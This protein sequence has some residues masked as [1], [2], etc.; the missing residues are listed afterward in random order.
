MTDLYIHNTKIDTLE[1]GTFEGLR[2]LIILE[3]YKCGVNHIKENALKAIASTLQQLA[4]QY[5]PLNPINLTGSYSFP[6]LTKLEIHHTKIPKLNAASF[7][8][9]K[10]AEIVYV[11]SN[12]IKQIDCG[13]FEEHEV[14]E[15]SVCPEKSFDS[16]GI[17]HFQQ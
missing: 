5:I 1:E 4:I 15:D 13:T 8:Q 9:M 6:Q 16:I 12:E 7:S 2:S 14:I 10:K 11:G 3:I 17:V